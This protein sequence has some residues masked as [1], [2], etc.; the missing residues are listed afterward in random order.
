MPKVSGS[1]SDIE[2][3]GTLTSLRI[4]NFRL[5]FIGTLLSNAGQWI[6]QV[7]LSWF[8]YDLTGSGTILGEG[9][10][11]ELGLLVSG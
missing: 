7:T 9:F 6:Q 8:V 2:K 4:P 11:T 5:L 3:I 1:D 10:A